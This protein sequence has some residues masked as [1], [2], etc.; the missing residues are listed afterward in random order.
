MVVKEI[1]IGGAKVPIREFKLDWM[2]EDPSVCMIAKRGNGKSWV[3]RDM[4]RQFDDIP[5]GVII[6]PTD[7]MSSFYGKFFPE[8]YIHYEYKSEILENILHRQSKIIDKQKEKEA[9]GRKINPHALLLMDDCLSDKGSWKHDKPIYEVM[10]NGRHYKLMFV[11]TMQFPLGIGPDLR[12][13]FDYIFL[14]ADDFFSN[15]KRIYDHYAGMFPNFK[16]FRDA[17]MQL[18][19]D[20]GCMVIVNR[21]NRKGIIDKIFWYKSTDKDIGMIGCKQ[22]KKF[23]ERNYDKNWRNREIDV[24]KMMDPKKR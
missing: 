11:L 5:G 18:T 23:H 12:N 7:K 9:R 4:L 24:N 14:L 22:F 3:C 20:Y 8:L 2:C 17:F 1:S 15:Q 19:S 13:N 21:G 10:F 16:V 6:S